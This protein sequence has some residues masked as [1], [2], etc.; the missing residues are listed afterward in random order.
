MIVQELF[1]K[2]PFDD[3]FKVFCYH[4]SEFFDIMTDNEITIQERVEKIEQLKEAVKAGYQACIDEPVVPSEDVVFVI[5]SIDSGYGYLHSSLVCAEDVEKPF[6]QIERYAYEFEP[7]EIILGY[8]V[9]EGS[10]YA[11]E[12][13]EVL[14]G[15]FEELSFFGLPCSDSAENRRV[16]LKCEIDNAVKEIEEHGPEN[17]GVSA[18]DLFSELGWK[19]ERSEDEKQF[20]LE[21]MKAENEL[22]MR[23]FKLQFE[24]MQKCRKKI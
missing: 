16:E 5:P 19:D 3:F 8:Q 6:D 20:D 15:I 4:D 9:S 12:E 22:Y 7:I 1:K 10:L 24:L 21:I 2:V 11:L 17:V 23:N 13:A 18:K 14:Y